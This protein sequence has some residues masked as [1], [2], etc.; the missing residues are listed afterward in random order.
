[1][2]AKRSTPAGRA[3]P[4]LLTTLSMRS[5]TPLVVF[6]NDAHQ[7]VSAPRAHYC[8]F[9]NWQ[10]VPNSAS[11][12]LAVPQPR[13]RRRRVPS[14]SAW[15][16]TSS[17]DAFSSEASALATAASCAVRQ[18]PVQAVMLRTSSARRLHAGGQHVQAQAN[19]VVGGWSRIPST[20]T[21][22]SASMTMVTLSLRR[23]LLRQC[24]GR[25]PRQ[26]QMVFSPSRR[27]STANFARP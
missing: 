15:S 1:M 16:M 13:I 11:V 26:R 9:C 25:S 20:M 3:F 22:F 4:L 6:E 2:A 14:N 12:K 10:R 18:L 24:C 19:V 7:S 17:T 5:R 8:S 21:Y 27:T 23:Q